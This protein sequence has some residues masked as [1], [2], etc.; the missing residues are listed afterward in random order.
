LLD[1]QAGRDTDFD[2]VCAASRLTE[3][4]KLMAEA[5]RSRFAVDLDHI[6][7]QLNHSAQQPPASQKDPLAELARIVGQDDPFR[8]LLAA[9]PSDRKPAREP[10]SGS[11]AAPSYEETWEPAYEH[12]P[13]PYHSPQSHHAP[14]QGYTL[15]SHVAAE[16]MADSHGLAGPQMYPDNVA[17]DYA[18]LH[19]GENA[20]AYGD[21]MPVDP[22]YAQS[23]HGHGA[24]ASAQS[25]SFSAPPP[26]SRKG[27]M[28]VGAVLGLAVLGVGGAMA[29]RGH[30]SGQKAGGEPPVVTADASPTK[31]APQNPGGVEIPDQNKQI[32]ERGGQD[33]QTKI[34]SREEQP[35]DVRQA[36][37]VASAGAG[38]PLP[39][40]VVPS[41]SPPT[42][43]QNGA[44]NAALGE[45][46]RVRTVSVGPDGT[47]KTP[48]HGVSRPAA[49]SAATPQQPATTGATAASPS[50]TPA[51]P[52][53][54]PRD[55]TSATPQTA[56]A[57]PATSAASES[58]TPSTATPDAS[59]A[60][61]VP[62]RVAAAPQNPAAEPTETGNTPAAASG[63]YAI[64]L[65]V[66]PSEK[67]A[68][69][70][71]QQLQQ[72]HAGELAGKSPAIRRAE[73]NGSTVYRVR[74]GPLSKDEA[75]SLCT[76]LQSSGGQCFVAKN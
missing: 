65:A 48:D 74:V 18:P 57:K 9:E 55:M 23:Q 6:E 36:T 62:Q 45:P 60:A 14:Y 73:V 19:A 71:F 75:S 27:L 61:K 5:M 49:G 46:R 58:N 21:Y 2:T 44:I 72:R 64:Q 50:S 29:L 59:R 4:W 56:P 41:A 26:R 69:A 7:R 53:Q 12:E 37:R 30:G 43:P 35:I 38:G 20:A 13:E 8:V 15:R 67:E 10:A 16:I 47:L 1:F 11:L 52:P 40:N 76:R 42:S 54:R 34:V 22:G 70:A 32:Y 33:G 39:S 24:A 68:K 66:R 3:G 51:L 25:D 63:G 28:A 31:V 17:T